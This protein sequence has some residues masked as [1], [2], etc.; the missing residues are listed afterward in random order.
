VNDCDWRSL[1]FIF[2]STQVSDQP[3]AYKKLKKG[4]KKK[5]KTRGSEVEAKTRN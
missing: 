4:G 3:S 1:V 5:K 2:T